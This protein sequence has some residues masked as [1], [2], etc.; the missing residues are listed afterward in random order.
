MRPKY[1]WNAS[2][3][4]RSLFLAAGLCL[5]LAA[6][7]VQ[8]ASG[9]Q[10]PP[11]APATEKDCRAYD[12]MNLTP[13]EG[14]ALALAPPETETE[15]KEIRARVGA[16]VASLGFSMA[17]VDPMGSGDMIPKPYV[18]PEGSHQALGCLP[19]GAPAL[20]L[21]A[22]ATAPSLARVGKTY[23]VRED[24]FPVVAELLPV[25]GTPGP[26]KPYLALFGL[27]PEECGGL[28]K[29]PIA[30]PDEIDRLKA[31]VHALLGAPPTF[32][33]GPEEVLPTPLSQAYALDFQ[34][35]TVHVLE[36]YGR[37]GDYKQRQLFLVRDG[38]AQRLDAAYDCGA[39]PFFFHA[40]GRMYAAQLF[41]QCESCWVEFVVLD[42]S[43]E[44]PAPVFS[45]S[46]FTPG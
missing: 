19:E 10:V 18:A 42:I 41:S 34:G 14:Y 43:G 6:R 28:P 26:A 30:D 46:N 2:P 44:T 4:R 35:K 8:G 40:K 5:L 31:A 37:K 24:F 12:A 7:P 9:K 16:A 11:Y 32:Q 38:A 17:W 3:M 15:E 20:V 1:L 45:N 36:Y 13:P 25:S 39:S 33:A 29:R 21:D 22:E 27:N 23:A